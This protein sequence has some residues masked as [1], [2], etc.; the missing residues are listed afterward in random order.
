MKTF[1]K[2]PSAGVVMGHM[3]HMMCLI[4]YSPNN[5]KGWTGY[6]D[7]R[8]VQQKAMKNISWQEARSLCVNI[9][10]TVSMPQHLVVNGVK[11][12]GYGM[13]DLDVYIRKHIKEVDLIRQLV[14]HKKA[15]KLS[16]IGYNEINL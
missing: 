5:G 8:G 14:Y 6:Y 12:S 16:L 9:F 1:E 13:M 3:D 10:D 15:K 4:G 7:V 2:W 11:I